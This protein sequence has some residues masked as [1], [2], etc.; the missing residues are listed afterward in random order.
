MSTDTGA[1]CG[2]VV[3]DYAGAVAVL[4]E[5]V[6]RRLYVGSVGVWV[7]LGLDGDGRLERVWFVGDG[8]MGSMAAA[9]DYAAQAADGSA[10][11]RV[12]VASV[13]AY[14]GVWGEYL[15]DWLRVVPGAFRVLGAAGVELVDVLCDFGT[16]GGFVSM[17]GDIFAFP[18]PL[19]PRGVRYARRNPFGSVRVLAVA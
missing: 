6:Q 2:R 9:F 15:Y 14:D 4:R 12:L 19:G 8:S 7:V 11:A 13:G 17:R 3:G 18:P 10:L 16:V 5:V 1:F